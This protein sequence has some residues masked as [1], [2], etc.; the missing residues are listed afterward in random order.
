MDGLRYAAVV[1]DAHR[2]ADSVEKDFD[3][4]APAAGQPCGTLLVI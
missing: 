2:T 3:L 1:V 4:I